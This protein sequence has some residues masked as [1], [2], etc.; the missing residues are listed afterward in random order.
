MALAQY[1]EFQPGRSSKLNHPANG[2]P[3]SLVYRP[4]CSEMFMDYLHDSK[5]RHAMLNGGRNR[6]MRIPSAANIL[7]CGFFMAATSTALL[8]Q[9]G[10][11][12][13]VLLISDDNR[14]ALRTV[15]QA[16]TREG[17]PPRQPRTL[18]NETKPPRSFRVDRAQT[19]SPLPC[20]N[21]YIRRALGP[22]RLW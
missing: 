9:T 21:L 19:F 1:S 5:D 22:V 4:F 17:P 10:P 13:H 20:R 15:V 16:L 2:R 3:L 6:Y 11:V 18:A 12:Q 8:A 7:R 14:K